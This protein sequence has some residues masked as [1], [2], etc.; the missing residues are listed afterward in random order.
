MNYGYTHLFQYISCCY[1]SH[2]G[3]F[4]R[5]QTIVSIHLMLLFILL[6][7]PCN[8]Y[9]KFVSIHLMLLFI[10]E[11]PKLYIPS[12]RF[13]YIS[14]CYLSKE[15]FSLKIGTMVSIHLM[16]L[17]IVEYAYSTLLFSRVSIHLMLLFIVKGCTEKTLKS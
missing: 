16:L 12:D 5:R 14:C 17:F 2:N 11:K 6:D 8:G 7:T 9:I 4:Y 1:L 13:Q 10:P 15:N 3:C